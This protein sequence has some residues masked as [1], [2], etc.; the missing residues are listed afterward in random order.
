MKIGGEARIGFCGNG[1]GQ[2]WPATLNANKV[3]AHG[4]FLAHFP[5]QIQQGSDMV[6]HTT[7]YGHIALGDG[8]GDQVGTHLDA[9]GHHVVVHTVQFLDAGDRHFLATHALDLGAHG[10]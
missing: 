2:N 3:L 5:H 7:G 4:D 9:V 8:A 10:D 1:D 6:G